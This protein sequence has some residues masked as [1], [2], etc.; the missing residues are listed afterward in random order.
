[1]VRLLALVPSAEVEEAPESEI[2]DPLPKTSNT[3]R[4][5]E[6]HADLDREIKQCILD[7]GGNAESWEKYRVEKKLDEQTLG[8]KQS[9]IERM[10]EKL[11]KAQPKSEPEPATGFNAQREDGKRKVLRAGKG[12][13]PEAVWEKPEDMSKVKAVMDEVIAEHWPGTPD[14][15][16]Q[17]YRAARAF[18]VETIGE[19][20]NFSE[21]KSK[22][23]AKAIKALAYWEPIVVSTQEVK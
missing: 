16:N 7:A 4:D 11:S 8:W 6:A 14:G 17:G 21:I 22:D 13:K 23:Q 9:L 20:K 3:P 12:G 10:R 5:D 15:Y 2:S 19:F 18:I 1:M